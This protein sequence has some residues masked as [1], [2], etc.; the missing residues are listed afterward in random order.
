MAHP[1]GAVVAVV[2]AEL[3]TPQ[4]PTAECKGAV[5]MAEAVKM[6]RLVQAVAEAVKMERLV[7]AVAEAVKVERL[8][9]AVVVVAVKIQNCPKCLI[10]R[11]VMAMENLTG[12][13]LSLMAILEHSGHLLLLVQVGRALKI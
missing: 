2:E 11:L 10:L 8:V 3:T 7:Q 12:G 13:D 4:R 6:E 1:L 9:Q 5:R